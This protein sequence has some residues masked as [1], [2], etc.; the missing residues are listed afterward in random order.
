MITYK[1][2]HQLKKPSMYLYNQSHLHNY[3]KYNKMDKKSENNFNPSSMITL[4][5]LLLDKS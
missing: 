2:P 3:V 5:R 4:M 1:S